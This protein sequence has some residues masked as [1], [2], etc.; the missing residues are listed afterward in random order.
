[1]TIDGTTAIVAGTDGTIR[2]FS[3]VSGRL[4]WALPAKHAPGSGAASGRDIRPLARGGRVLV[5]GSL[6]GELIAYDLD[7]RRPLWRYADGPDGAAALR[8]TADATHVYAPYTDGSLVAVALDTGHERWRTAST[9]DA[10]EWP[11]LPRGQQ[12]VAAGSAAVV[13]L[14]V[15]LATP[16]A[17]GSA[18]TQE[19]R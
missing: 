4:R 16:D 7:T 11:P 3:I 2:G 13:A 15:A 12:L 5:V 19:E 10:L 6:D 8:L 14:T 9:A 17:A 18:P 1:V